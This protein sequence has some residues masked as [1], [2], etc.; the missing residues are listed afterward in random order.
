M[1]GKK[2]TLQTLNNNTF[3][4]YNMLFVSSISPHYSNTV[5]VFAATR[6]QN[7]GLLPNKYYIKYSYL[8]LA[9]FFYL[10]SITSI[11]NLKSNFKSQKQ[12]IRFFVLPVKRTNYTLT[13]A[14]MA[15][16]KN[17]KEQFVFK[18][19][20]I[21]ATFR[22]LTEDQNVVSSTNAAIVLLFIVQKLFPLF[23]TNLLFLKTTTI[24]FSYSDRNFFNFYWFITNT[25]KL[26]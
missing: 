17:S 6:E 21:C 25:K 20:Y 11:K 10:K 7:N 5:N 15:H 13:K 23:S 14:P 9:W 22:G 18:S 8:I 1:I 16:K 2:L 12:L 26:T 24:R 4:E 19:Y 3:F